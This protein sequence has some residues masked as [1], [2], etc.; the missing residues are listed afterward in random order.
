M[1]ITGLGKSDR[2]VSI[3]TA[4]A[5]VRIWLSRAQ[6]FRLL[7]TRQAGNTNQGRHRPHSTFVAPDGHAGE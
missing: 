3:Y 5:L 4:Y 2:K 7:I 6:D 1:H